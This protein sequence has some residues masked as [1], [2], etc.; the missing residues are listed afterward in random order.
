MNIFKRHIPAFV[1]G[2]N[3]TPDVPFNTTE[4]LLNIPDVSRWKEVNKFLHF[5]VSDTHLLALLDEG[6][7]WWAV[8]SLQD[9]S[10]IN[11]P[12]W[13][14]PKYRPKLADCDLIIPKETSI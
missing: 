10:S 13:E 3:T 7:E 1:D 4:E 5:A 2:V 6:Y 8:G 9:T 11:L 14:G 12:K